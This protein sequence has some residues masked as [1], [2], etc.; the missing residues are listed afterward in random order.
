MLKIAIFNP[1][2]LEL[3]KY[4]C[5]CVVEENPPRITEGI[6]VRTTR[7]I[8]SNL[9]V[10]VNTYRLFNHCDQEKTCLNF[11]LESGSMY[12]QVLVQR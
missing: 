4:F 12:M 1:T 7:L 11:L 3:I 6:V 9:F 10:D 2:S 8:A 5:F